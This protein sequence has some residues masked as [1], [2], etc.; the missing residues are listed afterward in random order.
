MNISAPFIRRPIGTSLLTAAIVLAGIVAYF[1]LPVAPLPQVD[2][3]T[4]VVDAQLPG[5][6]PAI[7]AS[8]VAA[9]LERQFGHIS[10]LK[11]MTSSSGL[12]STSVVLEFN[13]DRNIDG[14]AR[15]VQAAINAARAN[16]PANLPHNPSWW[17]VNPASAP[18]VII[19]LTSGIFGRGQMYDA[20][21]SIIQQRL[22]Q[23][24]GVGQ[25]NIGGGALHSVR[26]DVNPTL[27]NSFG[28][29]LEDVRALLAAQNANLAKGQMVNSYQT[30]DIVDNDQLFNAADY[31]PLIVTYTNG[32]A[33]RLSDIAHVQD[34]IQ[35]TRVAGYVNG[36]ESILIIIF[37]T[38]EANIIQTVDRINATLPFLKASLP[39]RMNMT[40]MLDR[41]TTIRSSVNV[42]EGTLGIAIVLVILVVFIFLRNPRTILI[43]A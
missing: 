9:P 7:V 12:G 20:A 39:A 40:V 35:N 36:R 11:E 24:E 23:I 28:L 4:I 29:S 21:D 43:P 26:V 32:A 30:V 41:S 1:Q 37:P 25:V 34:S 8:S 19:A 15:D 27:L 31:K 2:L 14:A 13:L 16:L 3:P 17:K 18:I 42:V 5:A 33:V 6:S 22:L 10:G 38:P